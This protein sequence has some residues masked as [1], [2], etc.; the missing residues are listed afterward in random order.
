MKIRLAGENVKQQPCKCALQNLK[1]I[2]GFCVS[3]VDKRGSFWGISSLTFR[4]RRSLM[5]RSPCSARREFVEL[6]PSTSQARTGAAGCSH[7]PQPHWL[8]PEKGEAFSM[9]GRE[10]SATALKL[11]HAQKQ[12]WVCGAP[13]R[14]GLHLHNLPPSPASKAN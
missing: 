9:A 14:P 3:N 12:C 1:A 8:K 6:D 4:A 10:G 13:R 5:T 2:F 11:L 7:L